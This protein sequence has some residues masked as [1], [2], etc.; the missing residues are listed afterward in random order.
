M[1][2]SRFARG[3]A[4][5]AAGEGIPAGPASQFEGGAARFGGRA[6]GTG[7]KSLVESMW[8]NVVKAP[9]K[10]ATGEMQMNSPEAESAAR[11]TAMAMAGQGG[12]RG[13]GSVMPGLA[14]HPP[15]YTLHG[16]ID[17]GPPP[18]P[19]GPV[20]GSTRLATVQMPE[21]LTCTG[22]PFCRA[23]AGGAGHRRLRHTTTRSRAAS[24]RS[25]VISRILS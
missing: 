12:W 7:A 3:V 10:M 17:P 4:E 24:M 1:A 2:P 14:E 19:V 21:R 15:R 18:A 20:G 25:S 6:I 23:P 13:P 5:G 16:P 11:G 9:G 22:K 8:E